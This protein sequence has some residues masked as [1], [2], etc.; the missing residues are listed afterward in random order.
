MNVSFAP[1]YFHIQN[2]KKTLSEARLL[3]GSV[4]TCTSVSRP[5]LNSKARWS[6]KKEPTMINKKNGGQVL[7]LSTFIIRL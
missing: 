6:S 3:D 2:V 5:H 1:A 4:Y 7:R